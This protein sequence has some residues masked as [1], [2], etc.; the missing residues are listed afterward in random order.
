M[1]GAHHCQ[2]TDR[3]VCDDLLYSGGLLKK[4]KSIDDQFA[5]LNFKYKRELAERKKLH[6]IIQELKGNIRVFMR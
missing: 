6:N 4:V 1:N 5:Q 2:L 3:V